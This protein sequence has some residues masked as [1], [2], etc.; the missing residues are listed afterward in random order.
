MGAIVSLLKKTIL[1]FLFIGL[2]VA[3][4][5]F[6]LVATNEELPLEQKSLTLAG[7]AA[8]AFFMFLWVAG[9]AVIL[10]IHD[11]HNEIAE[12]VHRVAEAIENHSEIAS[13]V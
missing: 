7:I 12:G 2:T 3:I 9:I 1:F 6:L 8:T 4:V 11:R 10:S 5:A 13:K